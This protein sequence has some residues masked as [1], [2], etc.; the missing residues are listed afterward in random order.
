M[1]NDATRAQ[2][3]API[4]NNISC[5]KV[6]SNNITSL[7]R[8]LS[9]MTGLNEPHLWSLFMLASELHLWSALM[10]SS[11]LHPWLMLI[12]L[13]LPETL[14]I[15]ESWAW[16]A[17]DA[18]SEQYSAP[19]LSQSGCEVVDATFTEWDKSSGDIWKKYSL[20]SSNREFHINYGEKGKSA[21]NDCVS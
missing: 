5:L 9:P 3:G 16:A 10:L 2:S 13:S 15:G 11:E 20:H 21:D 7:F 4:V 17:V 12:V 6:N 1:T 18:W 8:S 14:F 19:L